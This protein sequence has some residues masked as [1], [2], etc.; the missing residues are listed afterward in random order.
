MAFER[1]IGLF[2]AISPITSYGDT[3]YA[4]QKSRSSNGFSID[5]CLIMLVASILRIFF[6]LG[7]RYEIS[8]VFQAMVMIVVQTVLLKLCLE[9]RPKFKNAPFSNVHG[10][11]RPFHFWQWSTERP[12]WEVSLFTFA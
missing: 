3:I 9:F 6:W 7:E 1:L 11:T 12:Y 2:L 5:L 10:R 4:I 8:L